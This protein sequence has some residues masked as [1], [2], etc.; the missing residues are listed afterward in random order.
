MIILNILYLGCFFVYSATLLKSIWMKAMRCPKFKKNGEKMY[1]G[2][3]KRQ[4]VERK[5]M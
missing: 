1:R 4:R 5:W 2:A 3:N